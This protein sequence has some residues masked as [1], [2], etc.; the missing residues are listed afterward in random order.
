MKTLI[1]N[2]RVVTAVDDYIADVLTDGELIAMI[3]KNIPNFSDETID[4]TGKLLIP[5]GIDPHTHMELGFGGTVSSDDFTTGTIAAA[6]GGTTSIIDFA[7]Q[8][9]GESLTQGLDNW[10]AK[11]QGKCAIDYSFHLAVTAMEDHH[12]G[13]F[14]RIME[15]GVTSF[16][17]FLAYP[18]VFLVDDPTMYRVMKDA[19]DQGG[20][21]LVH[22]ENGVVI[23]EIIRQ[24]VAEGK[25]APHFHAL[26]R[27]PVTEADGVQRAMHVAEL[28]KA[29]V[30]IVHVSCNEAMMAVKEAKDKYLPAYGETCTQYLFLSYDNYLEPDFGGAK[31]VMTPPLRPKENN[32]KLWNGLKLGTLSLVSTDH[33]PFNLKGQKELGRETFTKIPNGAPGVEDRLAMVYHGCMQH[34]YSLNKFVEWTSTAAAKMFGMFPKKGT[35][36][37]GSDA[38]LVIFDPNK[39]QVRSAKTQFTRC[40]YNQFEGWKIKG[41]PVTTFSRGKKI[42]DGGKYL[43]VPGEGKFVKRGQSILV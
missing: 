7:F 15:G 4:A 43:G 19:G 2:A 24:F 17:L 1:K 33:C 40:D 26:S 31:Y 20:L 29:P 27:P 23:E 6:A 9:K 28:A 37:V 30:F 5:G 25:A 11:A 3:G 34:G 18:G 38:D 21:T 39:E 32:E 41:A 14:K 42:F 8:M 13:E 16:K 12:R 35:I 36:A 22:A 10:H